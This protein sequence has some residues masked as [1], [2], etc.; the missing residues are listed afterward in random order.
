M[1]D[2]SATP[3]PTSVRITAAQ[4]RGTHYRCETFG[5]TLI[6]QPRREAARNGS[7]FDKMFIVVGGSGVFFS[8]SAR[9]MLR[10]WTERSRS[11]LISGA[12]ARA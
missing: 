10:G 6:G 2:E 8:A 4:Y 1:E 12:R 3:V 11:A 7:A 9:S 5:T